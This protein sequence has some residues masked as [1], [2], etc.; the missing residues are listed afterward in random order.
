M[1]KI[2]LLMIILCIN[3]VTPSVYADDVTHQY[4]Q[5]AYNALLLRAQKNKDNVAMFIL[6]TMYCDDNTY[7]GKCYIEALRWLKAA[8]ANGNKEAQTYLQQK[9]SAPFGNEHGVIIFLANEIKNEDYTFRSYQD[10][11][12]YNNAY[13][14]IYKNNKLIFAPS[15]NHGAEEFR[16]QLFPN[17]LFGDGVPTLGMW[18]NIGSAHGSIDADARYFAL[19]K[20]LKCLVNK[21]S[22][23]PYWTLYRF[24]E[25]YSHEAV[26]AFKIGEAELVTCNAPDNLIE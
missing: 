25:E 19:G 16:T 20:E 14:E 1:K 11:I 4:S 12:A 10:S 23:K 3:T 9:N 24:D 5:E 8:A 2:I 17:G 6:S 18:V 26:E 22:K 7:K 21:K 15:D 13:F